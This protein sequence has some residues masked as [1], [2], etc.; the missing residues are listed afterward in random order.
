MASFSEKTDLP[1][2]DPYEREKFVLK[3]L[4][5]REEYVKLEELADELYLRN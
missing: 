5:L 3:R 4:L 1:G 2:N